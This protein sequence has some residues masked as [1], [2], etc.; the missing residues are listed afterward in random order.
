M[1]YKKI[2]T[3]QD[4]SCVGQC[5]LTVALPILSACGHETAILPSAVL[6]THTAGF[7]GFTFRDLT[8]DMPQIQKH[9]QKENI[10]FD[11]IYTGY[12]GSVKQV[13]FVKDILQT[14]GNETAVKIVDPAFADGGKLY[15]IFD[16]E[17]VQ[18]M[19]TLCPCADFLLPNIS[20]ACFLTGTP[21][22]EKYDEKYID[23]L[24]DALHALG[25][26]NVVL[27]GVSYD[28]RSTGVIVS[29]G[30]E[31]R[32]YKHIKFDKG[33][34]GTGDVYASVFTGALCKGRTPFEAAKLAAN[35]VVDCIYATKQL[36]DHWYGVA[37]E[38]LLP[39]LMKTLQDD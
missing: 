1:T 6:S 13:G 15:S 36:P 2:L 4:I 14:M 25:A 30:K 10:S 20:E 8:D 17:Y 33:C 7:Q 32:Y 34:H 24:I 29:D 12:L 28:E 5:S 21:Y 27:T 39:D 26:K 11:C 38:P 3:I 16:D 37:F 18:A 19:K 35:F 22:Q 9:W 31:K 23:Q